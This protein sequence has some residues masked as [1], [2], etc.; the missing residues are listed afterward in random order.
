MATAIAVGETA[1][2]LYT[3][4]WSDANPTAA[5]THSPLG[6]LTYPVYYFAP[7]NQPDQHANQLSYDAALML[8][9][10]VLLIIILGRV[11]GALSRRHAE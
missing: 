5:L 9:A 1:P 10:F 4:N 11:V 6:Y 2:L 3:A 7:I 8:L